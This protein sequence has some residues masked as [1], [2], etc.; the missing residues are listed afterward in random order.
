[1]KKKVLI[2]L[3]TVVSV[4]LASSAI[5]H[6]FFNKKDVLEMSSIPV[7]TT[8]E[9]GEMYYIPEVTA[10][11]GRKEIPVEIEVKD[12]KGEDVELLGRGTR[13]AAYDL[14][15]YTI[16]FVAEE[17]EEKI[18]KT[19]DV[20]V[21]DTK[22]PKIILPA[23]AE[24]MMVKKGDTVAIPNVT[25]KDKSGEVLGAEYKV[26]FADAE[27]AIAKGEGDADDTFVAKEY[28]E[29][30]VTYTARDCFENQTEKE[31]I[32]DCTRQIELAN[33]D[34]DKKVWAQG[35]EITSENAVE[36]NALKLSCNNDYQMIAVYP[37]YYDLSGFDNLQ[38]T[39]YSDVDMEDINEGFYLLNQRYPITEGKNIITITRDDLNSQYP[40]GRI[41]S[42]ISDTYSGMMFLWFQIKSDTGTIWVDNLVGTFDNYSTDTKAPTIDLGTEA[43]HDKLSLMAGGRIRVPEAVA[44]DNSLEDITVSYAVKEGAGKDVTAQ[45]KA[46]TH[47]VKEGVEYQ[48][49]YTAT[50]KSGNVG[51][52]TVEVE[53]LKR[54]P[55]TAKENYF[56]QNQKYDMLQNFEEGGVDFVAPA[57]TNSFAA[58]HVM[59][60]EKSVC[61]STNAS[62]SVI[63]MKLLKDGA[64]L[65]TE[66]W[67]KYEYIQAY[68]YAETEGARFDFYCKTY[69]LELGPNVITISSKDLLKEIATASNVYDSTGGF[70]FRLTKGTVYVDSIIG[71]YPEKYVDVPP[72][73]MEKTTYF[74]QNQSY[75]MLQDFEN[76][77]YAW[78]HAELTAEPVTEHVMNGEKALKLT[79]SMDWRRIVINLLKDGARLETEDWEKYEYIQVYA[80]SERNR[81]QFNFY[82]KAFVL[83]RGANV[84]R[85]TP[86]E[87]K[88]EIARAD[89]VYDS[90]GGFL[91]EMTKGSLYIDSIIGVYPKGYVDV[92]PA[93]MTKT[94]YFPQEQDY[95]VLQNFENG[96]YGWHHPE[97]TADSVTEHAMDGQTSLKLTSPVDWKMVVISLL[98]DG[99]RLETGDWQKYEYIQAYVYSER[100]GVQFNFYGKA[101]V[102]RR[103]PNKIQITPEQILTE[104]QRADNVYD[105]EGGFLYEMTTGTVYVDS[106][107]GV[108]P[109]GYVDVPPADMEETTY[110][111]QN[112]TYDVLQDFENGGYGWHNDTVIPE[113]V[114]EHKMDGESSLKLTVPSDWQRIVISLLKNGQRLEEEDWNKY[115]HIQAY[116]YSEKA[117]TQFNFYGKAFVLKRGANKIQIT[118]GQ[119]LAE[120]ARADNVYDSEGGF[121]YELTT[122]TVYVDSIIG[123]YPEGSASAYFPEDRRYDTLQDFEGDGVLYNQADSVEFVADH[124]QSG[125]SAVKLTLSGEW[126]C[127]VL[128][129]LKDGA[130]LETAD[131]EEYE[132]IKM[133]VYSETDNV[134]FWLWGKQY[135][136]KAGENILTI[137]SEDMIAQIA[138][139]PRAYDNEGGFFFQMFAGTI[140]IDSIIGVYPEL[141]DTEETAYFPEDRRYDTLQDF[142]EDGVLYNQADS[143][144]FVADHKQSGE[145][146]VKLALSGEWKCVVLKLLKDGAR[147]ETADWQKYEYIQMS[148]YSETDNVPFWLW[149]KQYTLKAGEN[150]LTITSEDMIAQIASDPRA[151]DVEGGFFFQMFAGTIYIDSII[152]VYPAGDA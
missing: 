103:G 113:S 134:P 17:G 121:L 44:Y 100:S 22:G 85:I 12:S 129:L 1:M 122:G 4:G 90:T 71:V 127:V 94:S 49:V 136:L 147:L 36:G 123:V 7:A 53:I 8:A 34:D 3:L 99:M 66:D 32:I 5:L 117:G 144:E 92:P 72:A 61:L 16:R 24:N 149:G 116:V 55:D 2:T 48:I 33:F 26:E 139:D 107:I 35:M 81:V 146:A 105:S 152:G 138:S 62:D 133:S 114:T 86:E 74:P 29:Y 21:S 56:P 84:I 47:T 41:P 23:G 73:D 64:P 54:I 82:G 76:G 137:T 59:D 46:G 38:I 67:Q 101:F 19:L 28:G 130:R 102:L 20:Q 9:L 27:V 42:T 108:Y 6:A 10:Q 87:I 95:D 83:K 80:Y 115:E 45:V 118:P 109:K 142:E 89:E 57:V 119:I 51:T 126:K 13:F 31:V 140:Y 52:K 128:K 110:F 132:Y 43:A 93:D 70:Y 63:V 141:P 131:W 145:S 150:I 97:I 68:V 111:P 88:A 50:D 143:V 112:Q 104:I 65:E 148:V 91:Y 11:K 14:E 79:A 124:K 37:E 96:G 120:I 75:D 135:T 125:E 58:E 106:I 151:Y 39:V 40:K 98:K 77:G 60:G 30:I 25:W 78:H 18:D 69:N 15:G